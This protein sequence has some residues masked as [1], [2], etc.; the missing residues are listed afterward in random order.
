MNQSISQ[1]KE[2]I[3]PIL[4]EAGVVRSSL[5]GSFARGENTPESDIDILIEFAPEKV[6]G[7]FGFIGLQHKLEDIL[8]KKV[9]LVTYRS[10]N[11]RLKKY[12]EKDEIL[13]YR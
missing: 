10:I 4:K 12:I 7:F 5:F 6:M 8:G 1:L 9:D 3:A 13:I 2:K 11:H